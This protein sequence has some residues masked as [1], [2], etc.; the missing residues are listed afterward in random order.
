MKEKVLFAIMLLSLLAACTDDSNMESNNGQPAVMDPGKGYTE[1]AVNVNHNGKDGGQVTLRFYDDMPHVPYIS[2]S[3][4]YHMMLPTATMTVVNQGNCYQLTAARVTATVD[5]VNDVMTSDAYSSF[6]SLMIQANTGQ[7]GFKINSCPFLQYDSHLYNPTSTSV[8]LNFRKYGI[9]LHDDGREIYFPFATI[10]DMF[11]DADFSMACYDGNRILV[12]TDN[13]EEGLL[14]ID[15]NYAVPAY[16]VEEVSADMASY[17]YAELCFVIDNFYGY[18]GRNILEKQ[19]LRQQGLDVT[20]DA[21]SDGKEIKQL[22]K[23]KKQAEFVVGTEALNCLM[24]DGGHTSLGLWG[25]VPII[26]RDEFGIR[27]NETIKTV[28]ASIALLIANGKKEKD[29]FWNRYLSLW[30][31]RNKNFE[32]NIYVKSKDGQTAAFVMNSFIDLN[33]EGWQAY[34]ASNRT[35]ADWQKLVDSEEKDLLVQT[36]EALKRAKREGVKNLVLDVSQN[37]GGD[38]GPTTAILALLGDKTAPLRTSRKAYI[39]EMN[40]LT[41]QHLTKTFVVD[42]NFDGKFDEQDD[43]PDWV[44]DMNIVVLTSEATFSNGSVFAAYMRDNGY[45][46]WGRQ[47]RGGACCIHNFVTPDGM[48]YQISSYLSLTTDKSKQSID[49][50]TP[51]EKQLTFEQMYDIE[52]L[53]NLFKN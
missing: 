43:K 47:S 14:S 37:T 2:A 16:K 3:A 32:S 5:V 9:D 11:T 46:I 53:N 18:P 31:L 25:N 27:Y 1:R 19:G 42:R 35:E 7:A 23:S 17:R 26:V 40:M 44:G 33:T 13:D 52:Y 50:G 6:I 29:E 48:S 49:R 4:Y 41:R 10:N 24:D 34:Y 38:D 20:L 8:T 30:D 22:L 15:R 39:L 12:N 28:P 36:V 45:Q 21:V 51:V